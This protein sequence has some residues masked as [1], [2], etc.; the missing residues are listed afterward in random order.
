M[1]LSDQEVYPDSCKCYNTENS[2]YVGKSN[3]KADTI[4]VP[5]SKESLAESQCKLKTDQLGKWHIGIPTI[6]HE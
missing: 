1:E 2:E 6:I 3:G 4:H 5:S